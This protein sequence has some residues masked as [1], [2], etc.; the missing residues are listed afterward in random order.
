MRLLGQLL[1]NSLLALVLSQLVAW[2]IDSTVFPLSSEQFRAL[3]WVLLAAVAA[4][5]A[6]MAGALTWLATPLRRAERD[7]AWLVTPRHGRWPRTWSTPGLSR[8][9]PKR[10]QRLALKTVHGT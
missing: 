2:V 7:E 8:G 4:S 6:L 9:N 1:R 3:G 10:D 5:G